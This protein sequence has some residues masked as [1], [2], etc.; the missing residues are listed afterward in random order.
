MSAP[1]DQHTP[2]RQETEDGAGSTDRRTM[3]RAAI[4]SVPV[5]LSVSRGR[6]FAHD[7]PAVDE[8]GEPI[9]DENDQP[10][11]VPHD[12]GDDVYQNGDA[13]FV[14]FRAQGLEYNYGEG[15]I[16]ITP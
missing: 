12:H 2:D 3:L 8:M 1:K 16:T 5:I 13:D 7:I 4:A 15:T 11:L 9:L 10:V 6:M 14:N